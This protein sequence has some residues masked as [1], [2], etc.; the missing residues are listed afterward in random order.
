MIRLALA[1]VGLVGAL[2]LAPGPAH[3]RPL[4]E[5][6]DSGALRV[7]V[8]RNN[9]PWSWFENGKPHGIDVEIGAALARALG[10]RVE[11]LELREDDRIDDDLRN[12]VWRGTVV[13]EAP[14]DVML[15]VPYDKELE[16]RNDLVKLAAPYHVDG[17][18]MAVDPAKATAAQ[19]FSLFR[20]E[21][22]SVDVGTLADF[23][24]VSAFDHKLIPNVV[25]AR[26]TERA[27]KAYE[28]GEVVAVYGASAEIEAGLRELRR[29]AT[30]IYPTTTLRSE[31]VLGLA[32]KVNSRDLGYAMADVIEQMKTSGEMERIFARHGV[33]WRAPRLAE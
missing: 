1:L 20:T 5:V 27:F 21:K 6:R 22:V 32:V 26:G 30:L 23:I 11:Y 19:D 4:D 9:K 33:T 16:V 12:G 2:V 31:W 3:A 28:L 24:L 10:V 14:G 13:G 8:Y 25:H 17:L 7:T 15:H 29:P 18:A